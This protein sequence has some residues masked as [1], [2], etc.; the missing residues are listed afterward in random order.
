MV[1]EPVAAVAVV[2]LLAASAFFS[3]S[4]TAIFSLESHR[5]TAMAES[6]APGAATLARLLDDPHRLLVTVLV[7][8]NVV[9]IA[10]ASLTT[11]VFVA[12]FDAGVGTLAATLVVSVLVLLFGEIVPKSYAVGNAEAV[13]RRVARP[14]SLVGTA[15]SPVVTA[16]DAA[17]EGIRRL[18]GGARDIERPYVTREELAALVG[19][20][21]EAGVVDA[22]ER[23]LIDR[24]FRFDGVEVREV[25][26]PRADIVAI[27]EGATAGEAVER[28][29]AE[30]VNRL[31]VRRDDE[32]VVGYV[33]LRDL[34]DAE[35]GTPL[36]DLLL[37]VVHAYEGRDADDLLEELQERRLELAIVFDEFGAVEG[38]VTAEDIVEE[39]VG[40]VFDV[41]E[42]RAV[43]RVGPTRASARGVAPVSAVNDLLGLDLPSVEGGSVAA[44]LSREFGD[45][46]AVGESVAVGEARLTVRGVEENRV[47][48]VLVERVEEK[49]GES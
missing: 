45:V 32:R 35:P 28:C 23:A 19:A 21:A 33:D 26:V 27:D 7:G 36:S 13:A 25:M 24:V 9:N 42:P 5:I 12:R 15:L 20:A 22:D 34:V 37:P 4:E 41:G 49:E 46:P 44:L 30:R 38:L 14:I 1:T 2:G 11:A 39:L 40:E 16:F 31:P 47:T 43:S 17:N 29:A 6:D 3:G 48:R 18:V 10:V 8:N